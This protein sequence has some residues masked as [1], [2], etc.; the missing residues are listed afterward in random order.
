LLTNGLRNLLKGGNR[1][2]YALPNA[3]YELA[4]LAWAEASAPAA[5]DADAEA[6]RA[7]R[8]AKAKEAQG[9]LDTVVAWEPFLFDARLGMRVQ[10]GVQTLRW[11]QERLAK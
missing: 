1:D 3:H 6:T 11:F 9:H 7:R 10:A 4:A 8:T 2:D 5:A